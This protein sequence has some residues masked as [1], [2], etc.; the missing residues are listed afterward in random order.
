MRCPT[1]SLAIAA[2]ATTVLAIAPNASA[3]APANAAVAPPQRGFE[4]ATKPRALS[5]PVKK[6]LKYLADTQRPDGGWGAGAAWGVNQVRRTGGKAPVNNALNPSE[7][8]TTSFALLAFARAGN[9]PTAGDYKDK[10]A[11][12]LKFVLNA[13]EK[14]KADDLKVSEQDGSQLQN[15]IGPYAD[16]FLS[17][18][19]LAELKGT[20]G[21]DEKR[22]GTGL[23]KVIAKI[24]KNQNADGNL[25]GKA[26]GWA[27]VLSM[28]LC[29]KG[30]VKAKLAGAKVD[31]KVLARV[32]KQ[33]EA[34]FKDGDKNAGNAGIALYSISQSATNLVDALTT[35]K[36]KFVPAPPANA[37]VRTVTGPENEE[38]AAKLA[39]EIVANKFAAV[40]EKEVATKAIAVFDSEETTSEEKF[41]AM[42]SLQKLSEKLVLVEVADDEEG[43]NAVKLPEGIAKAARDA[44]KQLAA[45]ITDPAFTRGF[46]SDGGEEYISFLNISEALVIADDK[47][48]QTWDEQMQ[49]E[50]P[51]SQNGDGSWTGKH[52]I[53]GQTACTAA[54]VMVLMADRTPFPAGLAKAVKADLKN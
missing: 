46:G 28:G 22:L 2:L 13:V 53:S 3:V 5:E 37:Q 35:S 47:A 19:A 14:S 52:C 31:D 11:K 18:M 20:A 32:A 29:N 7:V 40:E 1:Y 44:R 39:R 38:A 15:K 16:T 54:A 27:P 4:F 17:L 51:K 49:K 43:V 12:G 9:T 21:D 33:A 34:A 41:Y 10:V 50:L 48:W 23:D 25:A 24:S 36:V 26:G 6:G 45:K 30:L 42:R 8:G